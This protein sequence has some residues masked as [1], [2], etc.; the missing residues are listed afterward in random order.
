MAQGEAMAQGQVA[1]AEGQVRQEATVRAKENGKRFK[2]R[3]IL[4]MRALRAP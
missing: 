1:K 4:E 2:S 3:T